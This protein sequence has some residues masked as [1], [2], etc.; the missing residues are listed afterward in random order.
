[1]K[2]YFFYMKK[3]IVISYLFFLQSFSVQSQVYFH[4]YTPQVNP[5][6]LHYIHSGLVYNQVGVAIDAILDVQVYDEN[7][8]LVYHRQSPTVTFQTGKTVVYDL[9]YGNTKPIVNKGFKISSI[10]LNHRIQFSLIHP[11]DKQSVIARYE[12]FT[13]NYGFQNGF[14]YDPNRDFQCEPLSMEIASREYYFFDEGVKLTHE[15]TLPKAT[16]LELS[17]KDISIDFKRSKLLLMK[18]NTGKDYL[19]ERFQ[20]EQE[21]Y[22]YIR[23]EAK[24]GRFI[25]TSKKYLPLSKPFFSERGKLATFETHAF[26][27]PEMA[28]NILTEGSIVLIEHA[29]E[30]ITKK[31][32]VELFEG[33]QTKLDDSI[34]EWTVNGT[35]F[36]MNN[37]YDIASLQTDLKIKEI[38]FLNPMIKGCDNET[39]KNIKV[40]KKNLPYTAELEI[41]YHKPIFREI[42]F[43]NYFNLSLDNSFIKM[44]KD[45]YVD[46]GISKISISNKADWIK[47]GVHIEFPIPSGTPGYN[48][49]YSTVEISNEKGEELDL[50]K[51]KLDKLKNSENASIE[52]FFEKFPPKGTRYLV[53]NFKLAVESDV[54]ETEDFFFHIKDFQ[55]LPTKE[56]DK[57]PISIYKDWNSKNKFGLCMKENGSTQFYGVIPNRTITKIQ[58]LDAHKVNV[59]NTSD[60]NNKFEL[61]NLNQEYQIKI[62]VKKKRTEFQNMKK[63]IAIGAIIPSSM[64]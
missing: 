57:L 4:F 21:R 14:Q 3:L 62:T 54:E 52:L 40:D 23:N 31:I 43:Q 20:K 39:D 16:N 19:A 5:I 47:S 24:E 22:Q 27:I 64:N 12:I 17:N 51:V 8:D 50:G 28:T 34:I 42:F 6:M 7:E 32:T 15:I 36:C 37:S 35:G 13:K 56:I 53:A 38:K 45:N 41:T 63:K 61:P 49:R 18:D 33:A 9:Y 25:S 1:M 48:P 29:D 26:S 2:T 58:V 44:E 55:N 46:Q 60:N 30:L 11:L 10:F 59:I